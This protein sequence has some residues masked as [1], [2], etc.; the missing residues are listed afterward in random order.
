MYNVVAIANSKGGVGRT[1]LTANV[2]ASLAEPSRRVLAV[3]LDEQGNLGIDLGYRGTD[4][5]DRGAGLAR[6]LTG[7]ASVPPRLVRDVRP[8]LDVLVGGDRLRFSPAHEVRFLDD[9]GHA[10]ALALAHVGG[11]YQLVLIDCPSRI[12]AMTRLAFA[13]AAGVVIPVRADDASLVGLDTVAEQFRE[14]RRSLNPTLALL[15]IALMQVPATA[16]ELRR[17]VHADLAAMGRGV[18]SMFETTIGL[19]SRAVYESRRRGVTAGE[20]ADIA[21]QRNVERPTS[22]NGGEPTGTE[23]ARAARQLAEEYQGLA[24]EIVRRLADATGRRTGQNW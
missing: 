22:S 12:G 16:T 24:H 13:A 15:G 8:G 23:L 9:C 7:A 21:E 19:C 3:D 20:F 11:D 1:A 4:A 6:A 5:D 10:L 18:F 14:V 17:H 2:A